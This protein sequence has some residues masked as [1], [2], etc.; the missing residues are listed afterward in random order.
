MRVFCFLQPYQRVGLLYLMETVF[1][2]SEILEELCHYVI[3]WRTTLKRF[4]LITETSNLHRE[5]V[6]IKLIYAFKT[7]NLRYM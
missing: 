3:L 2:H 6:Q 7:R 5:C 1:E 4:N